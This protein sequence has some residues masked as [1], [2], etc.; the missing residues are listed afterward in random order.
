[1]RFRKRDGIEEEEENGFDLK[2]S[3]KLLMICFDRGI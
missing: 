2:Y 1:M 3:F